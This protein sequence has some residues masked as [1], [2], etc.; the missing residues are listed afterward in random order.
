VRFWFS[1]P[2]LFNGLVRPGISLV[3]NT[4]QRLLAI[5]ESDNFKNDDHDH[6]LPASWQTLYELTR[7][8]PEQFDAAT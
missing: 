7:L 2:R 5:A 8:T 3:R 6:H 4:A 1:G